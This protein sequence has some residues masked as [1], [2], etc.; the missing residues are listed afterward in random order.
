MS[1]RKC[2]NP[3]DIFCYVCGQFTVK[4]Y[5]RNITPAI[6]EAYYLYFNC[7]LGHQDKPWAPHIVCDTCASTLLGWMR[8]SCKFKSMP[9][10]IPMIWR[11][12]RD[13]S[14]DCY[15]CMTNVFGF[16]GKTKHLINYPNI[17]SAMQPVPHDVTLPVPAPPPPNTCT[18]LLGDEEPMMESDDQ[19]YEE[20]DISNAPHLI[21]AA[22]LNDLVRD[23]GLSKIGAEL[24][25][26][27]LKEWNLLDKGTKICTFRNRQKEL[28]QYFSKEDDLSY[29]N[30]VDQLMK[31]MGLSHVV[32]EWRLFIDSS[33]VSLKAALLH[34]G[35]KYPSIP[36]GHSVKMKETYDDLSLLLTKIQY[37][38]HQWQIC[39]DLKVVAILLGM[40]TGYTKFCCFLCAWDSRDYKNHYCISVWPPRHL[41]PGKQNVISIPL[42]DS[43]KILL[44]PLHIKLGLMKNFVR[45]MDRDG[46]GFRYLKEKFPQIS[47]AKIQAGIFVGPQIRELLVDREFQ[48]RLNTNEMDAWIGFKQV[49]ENFLG[50]HKSPD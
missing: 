37:H 13:H 1:H 40:Q 36:V 26:S 48:R 43:H 11:E 10:G 24:L 4:K 14:S 18:S 44:P 41:E 33:K 32:S 22:D 38:R 6:E 25:G 21:T 2:K 34:N 29:C 17:P 30:N 15:F 42:V 31:A 16:T 28:A 8:G 9:F 39:A 12:P 47:E 45:A 49:V 19:D 5:I 23:L 35:N 46:E 3:A 7:K 27:R 20:P 50:N